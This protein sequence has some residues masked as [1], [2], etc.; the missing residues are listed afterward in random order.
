MN[1]KVPEE[2]PILAGR[3]GSERMTSSYHYFI[4]LLLLYRPTSCDIS[5]MNPP[6]PKEDISVAI[7]KLNIAID[8]VSK[9][10]KSVVRTISLSFLFFSLL[11]P[12]LG[13]NSS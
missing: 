4:Y 5:N 10:I 2:F 7:S 6:P 11:Y 3:V 12:S 13:R 1:W 8:D 9:Q